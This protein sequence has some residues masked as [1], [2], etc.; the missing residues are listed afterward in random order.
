MAEHPNPHTTPGWTLHT[1]RLTIRPL[2]TD[3]L[4]AIH[5]IMV[6]S[7]GP[8]SRQA[9]AA[10]LD[11]TIRNYTALAR[12]RQPP[13]GE[14]GIALMDAN[15]A[16]PLIGAVGLVPGYGPFDTLPTWRSQSKLAPSGLF[17]PEIGL[18]WALGTAHRGHGY[19]TEA[20]RALIAFTFDAL[21]LKRIVATTEYDNAA[22]IAVMRRLGM[23]IDTNPNP[24][25]EWFQVVGV[26]ANPADPAAAP[27]QND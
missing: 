1:N 14:R 26:L 15:D 13:Y 20:A 6:E 25:P 2:H 23:I 10:W 12:L 16:G 27:P 3:D 9:R 17:T 7:F 5:R 22:S 4:D 21:A 8:E 24:T 11:W 19:A 18:F